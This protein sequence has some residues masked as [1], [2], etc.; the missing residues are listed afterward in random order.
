MFDGRQFAPLLDFA[1]WFFE[2]YPSSELFG[3]F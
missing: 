2:S 1:D 3:P